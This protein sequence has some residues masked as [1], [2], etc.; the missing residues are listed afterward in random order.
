MCE[1]TV[2]QRFVHYTRGLEVAVLE[3]DQPRID[4]IRRAG[5]AW[6]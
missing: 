4:G 3:Q 6:R 1:W 5:E 2:V